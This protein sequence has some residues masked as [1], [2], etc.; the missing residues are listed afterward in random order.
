[1]T[2]QEKNGEAMSEWRPE[3]WKEE[4]YITGMS[5]PC[6]RFDFGEDK[7]ENFEAGAAAMLAALRPLVN[8]D[9]CGCCGGHHPPIIPDKE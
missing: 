4:Y 8:E 9:P 3:G 6:L 2:D 7:H 5:W 1:M